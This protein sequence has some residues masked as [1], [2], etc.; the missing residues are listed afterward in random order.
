MSI[1][2][3]NTTDT[4]NAG[5]IKINSNF[6]SVVSDLD[7]KLNKDGSNA[8]TAS[9]DMNGYRVINAGAGIDDND[10]I[11]K[12]QMITETNHLVNKRYIYCMADYNQE[13]KLLYLDGTS[14]FYGIKADS[15]ETAF[16]YTAGV[17]DGTKYAW[18]IKVSYKFDLWK[19]Q[20]FVNFV[21]GNN[22]YGEGR[23]V[24]EI[25]DGTSAGTADIIADSKLE[26]LTLVYRDGK[27]L[28][29]GGGLMV[30]NC[31]IFLSNTEGF[32][33]RRV[34]IN[35]AKVTRTRIISDEIILDGTSGNYVDDC[36][37]NIE[38]FTNPENNDVNAVN[39]SI[40]NLENYFEIYQG[41]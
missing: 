21:D 37:I 29:L 10:Y 3:I 12:E 9:L 20:S 31:D 39:K 38:N 17:N 2:V 25:A 14:S 41:I 24:V 26:G 5:R 19:N 30:D 16:N 11:T 35:G 23:P 33:P 36:T 40:L 22:V 6:D 1:Q 28:N 13:Y 15:P 4:P 27:E 7:S 34:R 18:T 8:M 32:L